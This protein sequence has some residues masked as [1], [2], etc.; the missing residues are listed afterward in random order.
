MPETADTNLPAQDVIRHLTHELRQPLS[1]LESIA[2]Y[3]QMTVGDRGSDI[4]AQVNRLQQ[5]VDS[6]NWV[7]SDVLHLLQMAPPNPEAVDLAELVD[8]VLSEAWVTDGLEIADDLT[9]GL[10]AVFADAEQARHLM[11]SVMQFLRRS[12]DAPRAVEIGVAVRTGAL[13]L[14]FRGNAPQIK[15]DTLFRAEESN[16]LRTCQ[17]IAETNHGA[18]LAE[19]DERGW[20]ALSMELPLAVV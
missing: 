5:M 18:F 13:R 17:R 2:F 3:L 10:P 8:D 9:E 6:A 19:R 4:T 15:L 1:A 20:L 16:P 11:R 7:L 14:T 12:V